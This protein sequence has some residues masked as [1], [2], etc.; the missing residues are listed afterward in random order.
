MRAASEVMECQP[1][2]DRV[3]GSRVGVV[4]LHWGEP[5]T[6]ENLDAFLKNVYA[7]PAMVR[8]PG[9]PMFRPYFSRAAWSIQRKAIRKQLGA[10]GGFSPATG[11]AVEQARGLERL[12]QSRTC[13]LECRTYVSMR[14]WHPG[15]SDTVAA[16]G[17]DNIRH[18]VLVPGFLQPFKA[19]LQNVAA[20]WNVQADSD[21]PPAWSTTRLDS[22][23]SNPRVLR[24]ISER[25]RQALQRFPRYSREGVTALFAATGVPG[26]D[27]RGYYRRVQ[28]MADIIIGLQG[29]AA[30][31]QVAF[32]GYFGPINGPGPELKRQIE[33]LGRKGVRNLLVVPL[34]SIMDT[35]HS[36]QY[37]DMACRTVA[38][39]AGICQYEVAQSL[40]SH[41]LFLEMLA[42]LVLARLDVPTR[43]VEALT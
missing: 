32:H 14:F 41:R 39:R 37:L 10:N 5:D 2:T 28:E 3:P 22:F 27:D 43:A 25:V 42:D 38:L 26:R 33:V 11:F 9:G 36:T 40:N 7:D 1:E 21:R 29:Q 31:A 17:R 15:V 23:A 8:L 30:P 13:S 20:E 16:L 24:A 19:G 6:P 4:L 35:L 12:L 18:V 34:C